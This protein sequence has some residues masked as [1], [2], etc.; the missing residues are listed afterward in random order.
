MEYLYEDLNKKIS[1]AKDLLAKVKEDVEN[2]YNAK[3]LKEKDYDKVKNWIK[4][5]EVLFEELDKIKDD[6]NVSDKE[7]K[8]IIKVIM[9][10]LNVSYNTLNLAEYSDVCKSVLFTQVFGALI[11]IPVAFL[12]LGPLGLPAHIATGGIAGAA[13]GGGLTI[14]ALIKKILRKYIFFHSIIFSIIF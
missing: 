1:K 8:K 14:T 4:A 11:G 5:A 3:L 7:R 6:K 12:L 2:S 10:F 9:K 13:M